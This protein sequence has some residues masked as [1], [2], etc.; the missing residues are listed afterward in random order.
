MPGAIPGLAQKMESGQYAVPIPWAGLSMIAEKIARGCEYK[1]RNKKFIEPPYEV[2]TR[3]SKPDIVE[4]QFLSSSTVI[5]FG[6][7][8]Q[9]LRIF[10]T[11]DENVVQY[12]ILVWGA[13]CFYVHLDHADY[14]RLEFDP[15]IKRVEG[16]S[17]EGKGM[18]IPPY[19][20]EFK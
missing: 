1:I 18:R 6:P 10:A 3:V 17:I 2:R 8:C 14:F 4:P 19:L 15:K 12:R 11:E 16:I 9:V 20:R 7:G 5:D 13:L